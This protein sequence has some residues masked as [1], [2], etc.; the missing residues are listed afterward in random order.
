MSGLGGR[1][2]AAPFALTIDWLL[3]WGA[4]WQFMRPITR[5]FFLGSVVS[6]RI[7][8]SGLGVEGNRPR[9]S[10]VVAAK[11]KSCMPNH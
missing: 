6:L 5:T 7:Y 11:Y 10:T 8:E 1:V 4:A 3:I 2:Q 9:W